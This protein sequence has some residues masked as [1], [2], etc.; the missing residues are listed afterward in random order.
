MLTLTA[1]EF[2]TQHG[3]DEA[4][5]KVEK[6]H[7]EV[8]LQLHD[9]AVVSCEAGQNKPKTR[10]LHDATSAGAM[11]GALL[12]SMRDVGISDDFIREVGKNA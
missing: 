7:N 1:R 4:L 6:L 8:L 9:A 3:A 11:S 2:H 12:G 10:E 5:E